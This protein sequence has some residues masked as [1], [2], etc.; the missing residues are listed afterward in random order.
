M[1]IPA[2]PGLPTTTLPIIRSADSSGLDAAVE[3]LGSVPGLPQ[4]GGYAGNV[5]GRSREM[6]EYSRDMGK[7]FGFTKDQVK[8]SKAR[9]RAR[10]K[11][12]QRL[13]ERRQTEDT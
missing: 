5:S 4:I 12:Q 13:A 7:A 2:L 6:A 8:V 1:S 3:I 11:A 10:N 9:A